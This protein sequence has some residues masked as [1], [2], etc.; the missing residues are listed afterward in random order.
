MPSIPMPQPL[1]E[2]MDHYGEVVRSRL[3]NSGLVIGRSSK[4]W[5]YSKTSGIA[6]AS[7]FLS[8]AAGYLRAPT[9]EEYRSGKDP[10]LDLVL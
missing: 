8:P 9:F 7:G 1:I 10:V 2:P 4:F 5:E 3:P 6:P